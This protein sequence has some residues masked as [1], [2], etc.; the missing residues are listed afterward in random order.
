M[1]GGR[2]PWSP[3]ALVVLVIEGL[4]R[5]GGDDGAHTSMCV[6]GRGGCCPASVVVV[7]LTSAFANARPP[8]WVLM[9]GGCRLC[10]RSGPFWVV[11]GSLHSREAV[12]S[13]YS[14]W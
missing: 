14:G 13:I 4:A 5:V 9:V 6:D 3:S 2:G 12:V 8:P 7:G 10:G 1:C 11:V